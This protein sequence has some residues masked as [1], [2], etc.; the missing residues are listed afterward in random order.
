MLGHP[1][2]IDEEFPTMVDTE[3]E[4]ILFLNKP[5]GASRVAMRSDEDGTNLAHILHGSD[6]YI[7]KNPQFAA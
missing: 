2:K 7:E 4:G 5:I 6:W 1:F 3:V